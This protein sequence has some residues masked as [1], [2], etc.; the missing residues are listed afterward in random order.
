MSFGAII[1]LPVPVT[2]YS[3]ALSLDPLK[4]VEKAL[5]GYTIITKIPAAY[6]AQTGSSC[7]LRLMLP[8]SAGTISNVYIGQAAT[9]GNAYDFDG[10]QV[11]VQFNGANGIT[12]AASSATHD[13]LSDDIAFAITATEAVLVAFNVASSTSLMTTSTLAFSAT[14]GSGIPNYN[15]NSPIVSYYHASLSEA[16]STTKTAS[17]GVQSG[18]DYGVYY[19]EAGNGA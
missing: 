16:G 4:F 13:I 1:P 17:Y 14:T 15:K 12:W 6:I 11:Q 2:N 18:V 10:G 3:L 5:G 8:K 19:I 7:R 9:S